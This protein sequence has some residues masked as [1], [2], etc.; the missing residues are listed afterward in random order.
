MAA[1]TN[2]EFEFGGIN[3]LALTCSDMQRTVD[4]YTNILGMKLVKTLEFTHD[5]GCGQ[6][7]FFDVG[8][9]RDAIAFFWFDDAPPPAPGIAQ[10]GRWL[11]GAPRRSAI[12]A[13][14]HVALDVPR[15]KIE[16][17]RDK[18]RAKGIAVTEVV[19]HSDRPGLAQYLPAEPNEDTFIR[20]IYFQD[21]DGITLES[22]AD[23]GG[24]SA[25]AQDGCRLALRETG[26]N[27]A[28]SP[29]RGGSGWSGAAGHADALISSNGLARLKGQDLRARAEALI[30]IAHPHFRDELAKRL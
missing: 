22:A 30:A 10:S 15:D 4:F 14:D 26:G 5:S 11:P 24:R 27:G 16:A 21:P 23:R 18:L 19:N 3:H 29:G 25:Q 28:S 8:N 13:M 12:G 2:T 9:G 7:F 20:S 6:H 17:Y 1:F